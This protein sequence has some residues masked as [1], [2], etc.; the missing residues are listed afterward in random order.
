MRQFGTVLATVLLISPALSGRA[1]ERAIDSDNPVREGGAAVVARGATNAGARGFDAALSH[2]LIDAATE[3]I[4]DAQW[5]DLDRPVPVGS[6]IK[7][8]TALAYAGA[9][10]FVYPSYTCH[11][12]AECWLPRGHGRVDLSGA[13]AGSCNAYF[14]RLAR[15]TTPEAFVAT[16]QRFGLRAGAGDATVAAMVGLSGSLKLEPVS[17]ARAYLELAARA[18]QPGVAP[19]VRGMMASAELG[20]GRGVG[21]SLLHAGAWAKTGTAPCSHASKAAAD[22]YAIVVYPVERPRLVL[23]VQ[24]HGRTGAEAAIAAGR[25]LGEASGVH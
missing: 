7:P 14:D 8:F 17:L 15:Q 25:I 2:V 6:L 3:A 16:L 5:N 23:L 10:Q 13:I 11:G 12:G 22:G 21:R 24:A 19:I 9:H 20:T 4:V 1:G 18:D